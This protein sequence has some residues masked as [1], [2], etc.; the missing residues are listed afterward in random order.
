MEVD[1]TKAKYTAILSDLHLCEKEPINSKHPLWKKYKTELFFFDSEFERLL[2]EIEE[3]ANGEPVE[4]IFAGDTFDFDS[5]IGLPEDPPYRITSIE[6][7][8]GLHAQE[9]KSIFKMNRILED[10]EIWVKALREFIQ[11]GNRVVFIIGNHDLELHFK[12][13]KSTFR[14]HLNLSE[15]DNKRV[16]FADWF[17]ISNEDTLV[18][19]GNQYDPFCLIVDPVSPFVQK[20][21]RIEVRIP[22]GNLVTRYLANAMGFFN[23]HSDQNYIM[24]AKE[25]LVFIFKYVIT[26]QPFFVLTWLWSSVLILIQSALDNLLP[27]LREP[28]EIEGKIE[29]IAKRSNATAQMVRELRALTVPYVASQPSLVLKELWLDRALLVTMAFL[30]IFQLFLIIDSIYD[31][32]FFW[33]FIPLFLF[34]PFFVFY[35]KT[36]FSS[37]ADSKVPNEKIMFSASLITGVNRVVYGHTHFPRHEMIGPVEHLNSGTWS[38]V[39][40]DVE[41]KKPL[42]KKSYVWIA[43]VQGEEELR[44]AKLLYFDEAPIAQDP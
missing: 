13:V 6:K 16:R 33:F 35:S 8:R 39:F 27:P 11:R 24:S 19:H 12:F 15:E 41:C 20:A 7:T 10:H 14:D 34:F 17:Y 2:Q 28:L 31:V 43:P 30:V 23:P 1:F 3:K 18:E 32:S 36:V 42:S 21:N 4:L 25:Y 38:P 22:F 37:V 29:R 40:E 9:P 26:A 5:V 44:G